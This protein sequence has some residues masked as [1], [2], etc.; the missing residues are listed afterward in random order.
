MVRQQYA[1]EDE[2]F[3]R[4]YDYDDEWVIAA[5]VGVGDDR[6]SVD[7]VGETAIVLVDEETAMEFDLPGSV[8]SVD[9]NNGV[10]VVR[11][12]Q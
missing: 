12:T 11:G 1:G 8:E 10:L 7:V 5:D 6:L 2:R 3:V 9:T 4:R